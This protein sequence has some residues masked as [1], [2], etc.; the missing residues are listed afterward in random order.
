VDHHIF[1]ATQVRVSRQDQDDL[2]GCLEKIVKISEYYPSTD[3][4][5]PI[6]LELFK[7]IILRKDAFK[8]F[9]KYLSFFVPRIFFDMKAFDVEDGFNTIKELI[10]DIR[11]RAEN[12]EEEI[13]ENDFDMRTFVQWSTSIFSGFL[14]SDFLLELDRGSKLFEEIVA[15]GIKIVE[16][17][18]DPNQEYASHISVREALNVIHGLVYMCPEIWDQLGHLVMHVST[19]SSLL[20]FIY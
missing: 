10:D 14:Q 9:P 11:H 3:Q 2:V 8:L 6:F 16:A 20:L 19:L 5:R 18:I 4:S 13:E 17:T 1:Q 7:S 12:Q 15:Y